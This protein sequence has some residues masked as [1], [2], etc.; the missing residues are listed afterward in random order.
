MRYRKVVWSDIFEVLHILLLPS[1]SA[2]ILAVI[3]FCLCLFSPILWCGPFQDGNVYFVVWF[4]VYWWHFYFTCTSLYL[5][6][7]N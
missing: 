7:T 2:C 1:V 3:S 5:I 4:S 6:V